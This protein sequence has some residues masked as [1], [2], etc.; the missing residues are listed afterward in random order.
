[1]S[2]RVLN[3]LNS[4]HRRGAEAF[5]VDLGAALTRR[6]LDVQTVALRAAESGSVFDVEA[7]A[8]T[9]RPGLRSVRRLVSLTRWA[10][11]M[12][13]HGGRTL[14]TGATLEV[15][16][17]IP[18]VYR[19][20]GEPGAWATGRLRRSRVRA[21]MRRADAIVVYYRSVA[22]EL[23]EQFGVSRQ[24]VQVIPKGIDTSAFSVADAGTRRSARHALGIEDDRIV[25]AYLGALGERK[26]VE[27]V[28]AAVA[29]IDNARLLVVGDGDRRQ[30][31]EQM[32]HELGADVTFLPSTDE[33]GQVLAAAD[34][35]A[36]TSRTEGVPTVL[37]EAA[38]AGVPVVATPVG[39]VSEVVEDG[40]TGILVPLD[41]VQAAATGIRAA[42][43]ARQ[44]MGAEA[45]RRVVAAHDIDAV[46]ARWEDLLA[47]AVR[48]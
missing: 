31:L 46:A 33:P 16:T 20:I 2:L 45:R 48:S 5:G 24:R 19:V 10:D 41:D 15:F 47:A 38:L 1:M 30:A 43:T 32:A 6:G 13:G 21:A 22:D 37:L 42:Y 12:I 29:L 18:F 7:L 8:A 26:N 9:G 34:V 11:V 36:L 3:L 39:G 23:W 35:L 28:L 14:V 40:M 44:S 4:N 25:V 27:Q 17:R